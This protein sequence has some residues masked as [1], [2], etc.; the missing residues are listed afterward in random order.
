MFNARPEEFAAVK[1][2]FAN[3]DLTVLS[4]TNITDISESSNFYERNY[5][6]YSVDSFDG[7]ER[8]EDWHINWDPNAEDEPVILSAEKYNQVI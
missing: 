5:R 3:E 8:V 7:I 2:Y 1:E 6:V 4:V